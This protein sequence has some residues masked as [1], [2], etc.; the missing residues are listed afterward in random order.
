MSRIRSHRF[1]PLLLGVLALLAATVVGWNTAIHALIVAP[2]PL[3]RVMLA[4]AAAFVAVALVGKSAEMLT[5]SRGA[6]DLVRA[7]RMAF[8]AVA[9]FAAA[10]GFLLGS[11]LP[12]VVALLIA[13]IDVVETSFLLLVTAAAPDA[14]TDDRAT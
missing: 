13:G 7:V 12:I 6:R 10:A 1:A 5:G 9:A 11:A 14:P 3:V 8:L 4:L 2:P